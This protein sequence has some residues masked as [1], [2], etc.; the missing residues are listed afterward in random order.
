V[1]GAD[2]VVYINKGFTD[3][4]Q[5]GHILQIV[6]AH[7]L[8]D[9]DERQE[10][11]LETEPKIILPDIPVGLL[12]VVES[13]PDSSTG[14]VIRSDENIKRGYYVKTYHWDEIPNILQRLKRCDLQ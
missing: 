13:R 6:K 10:I 7:I 9:P 12:L 3:G 4:V 14:V 11:V 8:P 5:R 2:S 1:I